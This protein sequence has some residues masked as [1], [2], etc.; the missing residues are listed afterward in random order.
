M[1]KYS[2]SL[3]QIGAKDRHNL[4]I[5]GCKCVSTWKANSSNTESKIVSMY[6]SINIIVTAVT[7]SN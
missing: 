3:V 4:A 7:K 1:E 6:V 2:S 5:P